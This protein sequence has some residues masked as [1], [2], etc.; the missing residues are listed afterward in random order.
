M[1]A[2][3][4]ACSSET[5]QPY[6]AT[7][8]TPRLAR[9]ITANGLSTATTYRNGTPPNLPAFRTSEPNRKRLLGKPAGNSYLLSPSFGSGVLIKYPYCVPSRSFKGM[10]TLFWYLLLRAG[11]AYAKIPYKSRMA[12]SGQRDS[13]QGSSI[14]CWWYVPVNGFRASSGFTESFIGLFSSEGEGW[15]ASGSKNATA[16]VKLHLRIAL[17]KSSIPLPLVLQL[18]QF[19]RPSWWTENAV[20]LCLGL[21]IGQAPYHSGL[22]L[23]FLNVKMSTPRAFSTV[24]GFKFRRASYLST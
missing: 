24:K 6:K 20:L 5:A 13:S 22:L 1:D 17:T 10:K 3:R 8:G 21:H 2:I 9:R 23:R 19:Q 12:L 11:F 7:A 14:W 16:S 15:D 18:K 4:T